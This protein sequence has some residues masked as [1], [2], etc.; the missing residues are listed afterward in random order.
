VNRT[1]P[2]E[3]AAALGPP[4]DNAARAGLYPLVATA[5]EA[6]GELA[7]ALEERSKLR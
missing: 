6:I 4:L 3:A 2:L 7:E 1:D 5:Q